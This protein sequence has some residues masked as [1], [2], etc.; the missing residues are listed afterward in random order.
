MYVG[1]TNGLMRRTYEHKNELVDG[2][3]KRY[4][5]K[6]LIY[7]EQTE[8]IEAA[9]LREKQLKKWSRKKKEEL[10]RR[11]NSKFLDLSTELEMTG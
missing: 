1:V 4:K 7:Y 5:C 11:T 8:S 6:K 9:I 2:F 10:I 3:T